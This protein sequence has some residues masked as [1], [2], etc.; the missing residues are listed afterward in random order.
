MNPKITQERKLDNTKV[1]IQKLY[2]ETT[3]HT[4][5][6]II[7]PNLTDT[8]IL[9]RYF[10]LIP[11]IKIGELYYY[12]KRFN[13]QEMRNQSYLL[14][15]KG[16]DKRSIVDMKDAEFI[17]DFSCYHTYSS[18]NLFEPK[19]AE[20]LSQFPDELLHKANAFYM[21]EMPKTID[22]L[23]SQTEIVDAGCHKSRVKALILKDIKSLR[24]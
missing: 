23:K 6:K 21:S 4:F 16:K 7:M 20:V 10:K 1:T 19:M 22:D 9:E 18:Y 14:H 8:E 12:L 15:A 2:D 5:S 13:S 3:N 17:G 24:L 11:I